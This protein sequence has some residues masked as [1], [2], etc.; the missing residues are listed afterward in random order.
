[1]LAVGAYVS[2]RAMGDGA[3]G[4]GFFGGYNVLALCLM[5]SQALQGIAVV[6]TPRR[7][8]ARH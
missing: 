7:V 1:M 3:G 6:R 5:L 8:D 2:G 4:P